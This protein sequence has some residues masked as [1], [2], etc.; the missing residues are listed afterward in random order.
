MIDIT[1][2]TIHAEKPVTLPV[3]MQFKD[4]QELDNDK[5]FFSK[6]IQYDVHVGYIDNDFVKNLQK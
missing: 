6:L 1:H 5:E 3:K 4:T 2:I